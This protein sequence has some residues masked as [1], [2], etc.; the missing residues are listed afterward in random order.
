MSVIRPRHRLRRNVSRVRDTTK[1]E[2]DRVNDLVHN[3]IAHLE[4]LERYLDWVNQ[5]VQDNRAIIEHLHAL[6]LK[7]R[8]QHVHFRL[9]HRPILGLS[10]VFPHRHQCPDILV[11]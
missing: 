2:L 7:T 11:P 6:L 4:R 1:T 9:P 8:R 10:K 5:R 3:H